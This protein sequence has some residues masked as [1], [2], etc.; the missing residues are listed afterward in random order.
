MT[1]VI[2]GLQLV[3][4]LADSRE[5]SPDNKLGSSSFFLWQIFP[6]KFDCGLAG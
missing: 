3:E 4:S 1:Y 5:M 2:P 6:N